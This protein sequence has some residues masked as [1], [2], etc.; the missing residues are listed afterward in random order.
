[1]NIVKVSSIWQLLL[2]HLQYFIH[3][4]LEGYDGEKETEIRS[5]HHQKWDERS[6]VSLCVH[7]CPFYHAAYQCSLRRN[8]EA[9]SPGR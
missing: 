8:K 6:G 2:H 5:L 3:V 9:N 7:V 4:P 1:M